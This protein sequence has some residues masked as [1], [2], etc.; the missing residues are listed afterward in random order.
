VGE[1]PVI[2]T[3]AAV[4]N[5]IADATGARVTD[6]PITPSRLLSALA[7]NG[8]AQLGGSGKSA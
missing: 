5:A 8:A 2:A 1:P 4:A 3:A 7:A 6:L